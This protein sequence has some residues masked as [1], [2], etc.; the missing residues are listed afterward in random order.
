MD[1]YF[2]RPEVSNSDLSRLKEDHIP[3]EIKAAAQRFGRL[4]DAIITEPALVDHRNCTMDGEQYS[5][6]DFS[7][8]Q[9]MQQ[10]FINDPMCSS[11]LKQST[12]QH[13]MIKHG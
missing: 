6:D 5:P 9:A 1:N 10:A 12:M 13:V 2:N 11:V 7:I 4:V 8:A 3:A